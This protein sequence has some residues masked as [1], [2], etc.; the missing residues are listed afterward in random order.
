L[1]AIEV[2]SDEILGAYSKAEDKATTTAFDARDKKRLNKVFDVIGF[3]YPDYY[4]PTRKQGRKRKTVASAFT[5]VLRSKKIKV[6]TRRPRRIETAGVP[7][8]SESVEITPLTIE[9]VPSVPIETIPD[10]ARE[11]EPKR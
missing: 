4:Y 5:G 8:L 6:P 10:L 1:D 11:P 3:V 2:T 7:K 9:I